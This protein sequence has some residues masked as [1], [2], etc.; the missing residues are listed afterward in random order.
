MKI[1]RRNPVPSDLEIAQEATVK[2]ILEIAD[3]IG[4]QALYM[5][6]YFYLHVSGFVLHSLTLPSCSLAVEFTPQ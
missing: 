3:S 6:N 4:L 2:P 1:H 5:T